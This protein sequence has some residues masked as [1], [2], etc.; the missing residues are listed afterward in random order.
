MRKVRHFVLISLEGPDARTVILHGRE[1]PSFSFVRLRDTV[2]RTKAFFVD[3]TG[4]E[5]VHRA[6]TASVARR[7]IAV[8]HDNFREWWLHGFLASDFSYFIGGLGAI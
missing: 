8:H 5:W 7:L 4:I 2:I 6:T 3:F 1:Y